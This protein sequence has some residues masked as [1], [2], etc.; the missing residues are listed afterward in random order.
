MKILK[1]MTL[2]GKILSLSG[3]LFVLVLLYNHTRIG[4]HFADQSEKNNPC[5]GTEAKQ[6]VDVDEML[7]SIKSFS[8]F[9]LD[10][11]TGE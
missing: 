6:R 3:F 11:A 10:D 9:V 5:T 7:F 1:R 4:N 8:I 2:H